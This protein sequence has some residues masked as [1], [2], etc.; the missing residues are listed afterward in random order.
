MN[1]GFEQIRVLLPI[2][3]RCDICKKEKA[4]F[5][6]DMPTSYIKTII[7]FNDGH[8]E[9]WDGALFCHRKMCEKCAVEVNPGIHFCM[10]CFK[11]LRSKG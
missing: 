5:S 2:E 9:M 7:S 1:K 4:V 6:C 10:R 3:E 11:A 8:A